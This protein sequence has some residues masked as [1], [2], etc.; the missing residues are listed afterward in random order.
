VRP[1][2]VYWN[3]IPSPYLVDKLDRLADRGNLDFEGWF[4]V[5][6]EPDRSWRV[7]ETTWRF[8]YRYVTGAHRPPYVPVEVRTGPLPDLLL[9]LY[10][11]PCFVLGT[12]L[13]R[14]RGARTALWAEPTF[15]S[16]IRRR[17]WKDAIK[18]RLFA[19]AETILTPGDDGRD[20]VVRYGADPSRIHTL[21]YFAD[22][23]RFAADTA[24]FL[25][26]REQTRARLGLT[27]V[28]FVY[29]GRFW[30]GKGLDHLLDAYKELARIDEVN[31]LLVGDGE[32]ETHLRQRCHDERIPGVV[33]TGF[34]DRA[35]LAR[36][37]TAAD[38]FV[39]PTLGD[40]FGMVVGEAASCG[41]PV[42]S[43]SAAGEITSRIE[44][45]TS[46]FIVPPGNSAALLER[47]R[48][49]ARDP[50]LRER[51]GKEAVSRTSGQTLDNWCREFE[52]T[53]E[54][55]LS[56]PPGGQADGSRA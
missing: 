16:W 35:E 55:I 25:P 7:D 37:Y 48:W 45:N 46:G 5:R 34:I 9:S 31:L 17:W 49:L 38:A 50:D 44:D 22:Y 21:T 28:T 23:E 20:F 3:N 56:R 29:V 32:Q 42:V 54:R 18:R 14:R 10:A 27:G 26:A 13:A 6:T 4:N 53:V 52:A 11:E 19:S 36:Y 39:F 1:R 8:P 2:V 24:R 40:P 41:L 43:T 51:M 33:F 15:D 12:I 30:K 47:M